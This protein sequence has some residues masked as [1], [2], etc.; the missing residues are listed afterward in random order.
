MGTVTSFRD[1]DLSKMSPGERARALAQ[2][3]RGA[4][5]A[6]NGEVSK[7]SAQVS[8]FERVHSMSTAEMRDRVHRGTMPE[9]EPVCRWLMLAE[10]LDDLR[11]VR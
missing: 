5:R 2:L 6:P 9:T 7:L 11:G 10:L 8:E 4:Q 1:S 3:A